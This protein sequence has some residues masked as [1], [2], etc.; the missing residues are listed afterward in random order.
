MC[1][2]GLWQCQKYYTTWLEA[3]RYWG[4]RLQPI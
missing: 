4:P 3:P 2:K 1:K